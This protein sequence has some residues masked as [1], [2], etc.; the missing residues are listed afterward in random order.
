MGP[1]HPCLVEPVHAPG[2]KAW[3]TRGQ[4]R[5]GQRRFRSQTITKEKT[6]LRAPA[7]VESADEAVRIDDLEHLLLVI[8]SPAGGIGDIGRRIKADEGLTDGV[9]R[10]RRKSWSDIV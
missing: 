6:V 10:A 9:E 2:T 1:I 7:M 5:R 8:L 4:A 3:H